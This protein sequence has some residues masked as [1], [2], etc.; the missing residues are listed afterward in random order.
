MKKNHAFTLIELLVVIG[1]IALLAAIATP[2]FRAAQ[3]RA[4]AT[5]CL[6]NLKNL[7][8]GFSN[9]LITN[10]G[11]MFDLSDATT[12]PQELHKTFVPDWKSF[13]SAFD[14][15]TA[16]RPDTDSSP[17]TVSYGVNSVLF[18][19]IAD[20]WVAP[21]TK[22]I[23]A[24]PSILYT[25]GL[26]TWSPSGTSTNQVSIIKPSGTT[27]GIGTHESREAI[28]VLLSDWHVESM[29]SSKF[30]TSLGNDA[31]RWDPFFAAP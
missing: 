11:V 13:R 27:K 23:F 24:A 16:A 2:M 28:N 31:D 29:S 14:R 18:D 12:W 6:N 4:R 9:H 30:S 10:D 17:A 7:G 15:P 19:T 8:L 21:R 20:K 26:L 25:P 22:L 3:E 1:I 5:T